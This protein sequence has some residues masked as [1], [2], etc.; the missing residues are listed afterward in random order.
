MTRL[1]W[2]HGH[3]HR[4]H[5]DD[6]GES[7]NADV[8]RFVAILALCLVALFALVR[9]IPLAA[10]VAPASSPAP[11]PTVLPTAPAAAEVA[12][13][14]APSSRGIDRPPVQSQPPPGDVRAQPPTVPEA[15]V[16]PAPPPL[17]PPDSAQAV[18]IPVEAPPSQ[19]EG[20]TLRFESDQA[21]QRLIADARVRVYARP[22][23]G[24]WWVTASSR[25][26]Q[27]RP[28]AAPVQVYE[29]AAS[30]VPRAMLDALGRD[31]GFAVSG[32]V[33]WGVSLPPDIEDR[34]EAL[35]DGRQGGRLVI[36]AG[37]GVTLNPQR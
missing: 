1:P 20:Y 28:A 13:P 2:E 26:A 14:P 33:L 31:R 29:M 17:A 10:P 37:G 4:T 16:A 30:T 5:E 9:S 24:R 3:T 21:L 36:D 25:V 8:M 15:P 19:A 23:G 7:L 32:P 18:P 22:E 35:V 27:F 11:S 34:I 12:M 6:G